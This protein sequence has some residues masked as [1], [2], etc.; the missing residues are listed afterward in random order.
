[1]IKWMYKKYLKLKKRNMFENN[2][3]IDDSTFIDYTAF[4]INETKIKNTI[5]IGSKSCIRGKIY[6]QN[7]EK[8]ITPYI[9]IGKNFYLGGNSVI[10]AV[11]RIVI[12]DN[13]II[14]GETRIFDNNNHPTSP[15]KRKEMSMCGN[16]FGELWKWN[17]SEHSP[18]FIEDNVWIGEYCS[19][20]KG[21]T[22]G[23]GSIIGCR[24][25]VTK[26]IPPYSIAAGNPA[27]VVKRLEKDE[28]KDIK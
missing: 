17:K 12:G 25:V 27:R 5:E 7:S 14:A 2:S 26:S 23:K 1:M 22:I 15:K 8:K 3:K 9:K 19:I 18:V 20:L 11:E 21:V 16:F 24:S 10:G 4:C 13:V 6:L 28:I